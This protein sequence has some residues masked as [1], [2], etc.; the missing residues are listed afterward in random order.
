MVKRSKSLSI[1]LIF[2]IIKKN[3]INDKSACFIQTF[4]HINPLLD[5]LG[6]CFRISML[7]FILLNEIFSP[8]FLVFKKNSTYKN[9]DFLVQTKNMFI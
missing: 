6:H 3:L 1:D 7:N 9:H 2:I 5:I 8:L 4:F